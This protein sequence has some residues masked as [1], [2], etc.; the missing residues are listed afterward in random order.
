MAEEVEDG[1]HLVAGHGEH[2]VVTPFEVLAR[3]GQL[4]AKV[5]YLVLLHLHSTFLRVL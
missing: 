4:Q 5:R 2:L 3:P 1:E